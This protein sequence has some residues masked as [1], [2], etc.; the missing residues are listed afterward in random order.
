MGSGAQ[1]RPV[2]ADSSAMSRSVLIPYAFAAFVL[3]ASGVFGFW[4]P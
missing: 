1:A 3:V 4:S 2:G